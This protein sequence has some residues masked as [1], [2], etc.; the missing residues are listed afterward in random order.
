MYFMDCIK[1]I[2]TIRR[3]LVDFSRSGFRF[4]SNIRI[5]LK[6]PMKSILTIV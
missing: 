6:V 2:K 4:V 1:E 5:R 3:Y